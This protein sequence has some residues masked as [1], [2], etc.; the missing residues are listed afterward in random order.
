MYFTPFEHWKENMLL[1]HRLPRV[2]S[3]RLVTT[4]TP[5]SPEVFLRSK[6]APLLILR[7]LNQPALL[8][9]SRR[10]RWYLGFQV[11]PSHQDTTCFPFLSRWQHKDRKGTSDSR[12]TQGLIGCFSCHLRLCQR[13]LAFSSARSRKSPNAKRCTHMLKN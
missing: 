12:S 3:P 2:R 8:L 6:N 10:C 1:P 11:T 9:C 7:G 5:F 4:E 13:A